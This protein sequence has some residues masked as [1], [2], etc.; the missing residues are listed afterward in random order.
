MN[1]WFFNTLFWINK[2]SSIELRISEINFLKNRRFFP[3]HEL[4]E[5]KNQLKKLIEE[6]W[7]VIYYDLKQNRLM[8]EKKTSRYFCNLEIEILPVIQ[9]RKLIKG[10]ETLLLNNLKYYLRL[11]LKQRT[12]KRNI[13]H[14]L[15][16]I[17]FQALYNCIMWI[18]WCH[19]LH[20]PNE[21]KFHFCMLT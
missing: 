20:V 7:E 12:S 19:K 9:C 17:N 4:L 21:K 8:M 6:K 16:L 13:I 3:N 10:M 11:I 18:L 1:K 14:N 2:N 5:R 15:K